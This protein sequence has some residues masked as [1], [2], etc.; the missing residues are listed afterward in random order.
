VADVIHVTAKQPIGAGVRMQPVPEP[1]AHDWAACRLEH[2]NV[3][4]CQ[5]LVVG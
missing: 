4:S 1:G 2:G 5:V 3:Q